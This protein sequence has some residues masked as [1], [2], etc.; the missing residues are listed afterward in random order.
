M[1]IHL[2]HNDINKRKWDRC[3]EACANGRPY[4]YSWFLD[5]VSPGWDALVE[6]DYEAVFPLTRNNKFGIDYLF[7]PFF[8]QQLGLFSGSESDEQKLR[9]FLKSIP[10]K[11]RFIDIQLNSANHPPEINKVILRR[12]HEIDLS[13]GYDEISKTYNQNTKRNIR[14]AEGSE[15]VKDDQTE[16]GLIV[17]LFRNNYGNKE[18]KLTEKNYQ[19]IEMLM[20]EA[21]SRGNGETRSLKSGND[22]VAAFFILKDKRRYIYHLAATSETGKKNGAMFLLIDAFLK[23]KAGQDMLFDFEGSDDDNVSRFYKGFGAYEMNYPRIIINRLPWFV[24]P[25]AELRRKLKKG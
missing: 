8:C 2:P 18:G 5:I 25:F 3:I 12:N 11:F 1:I 15:L 9:Q 17:D 19:T 7:Q 4:G 14:K 23:Q 10:V 20:K 6:D 16:P 13:K 22:H 24:K 21:I